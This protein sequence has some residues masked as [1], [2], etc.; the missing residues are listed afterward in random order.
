MNGNTLQRM[1]E[2]SS[3][4]DGVRQGGPADF[5]GLFGQ[6]PG[7]GGGGAHGGGGGQQQRQGAAAAGGG[8]AAA[9]AGMLGDCD[10]P[11]AVLAAADNADEHDLLFQ[12]LLGG[13]G[14]RSLFNSPAKEGQAAAAAAAAA[15]AGKQQQQAGG[16]QQ[17]VQQRQAQAQPVRQQARPAQG[18]QQ[19]EA[20]DRPFASLFG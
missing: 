18:R 10:A 3:P 1:L 13:T 9:L 11:A 5:A 12:D 16:Q 15:G 4:P 6:L 19:R 2:G 14:A 20:G 7:G 8:P 17:Q